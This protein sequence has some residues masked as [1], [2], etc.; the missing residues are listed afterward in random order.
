MKR[1]VLF[2]AFMVPVLLFAGG[3][4]EKK[5]ASGGEA[6]EKH[7]IVAANPDFESF[8][9]AIA[10]E[11]FSAWIMGSCYNTLME[12]D[13]SID[14]LIPRVAESYSVSGDGLSYTFSLRKDV[15]FSSGNPLSSADVK[16]S[17]ERVW[18]I[19]GNGSFMLGGVD[20]ID[21]PDDYTVIYRLKQVDPVFPTK[22]SYV[23]MDILDRKVAIEHGATNAEN[24]KTADTAKTW[25]DNNS[26]GSGPY[27]ILSYTPKVEVV[28]ERNP[29]YWRTPAYYDKITLKTVTDSN[30][31]LMMLRAGDVDIAYN[32]S[33]EQI[34][35]LQG[36]Q[37]ITIM[38]ARSLTTSFL[39]MN[40]DPGIG[41]PVANPKVQRAIRLALDY[42]G[43]QTIAGPRMLSP[44][45]PF[46]IGLAGSLQA[47]DVTG[48]P[49]VNEAKALLAEAGYPNGFSTKFYVP[50]NT[51]VGVDL[52]L[53]A[54]KVQNDLKAVGIN[55]ELV[56]ESVNISLATYRDGKQPLGLW[57]W[58]PDYIDNASQLAFLPGNTVGLRA[59][60]KEDQNPALAALGRSAAVE[61]DE[62]KR[63]ALIGQIQRAMIEDT[64]F[65]VLLQH[66]SQYAIRT[67]LTGA[68]YGMLRLDFK[69][70]AE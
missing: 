57:Y 29:N 65:A 56:P 62:A 48:Y 42:P 31:Q 44:Q 55:T 38:D 27:R 41:G 36:V 34:Q 32:L 33:P 12:Y 6:K 3:S 5:T 37:G 18:N 54:Q 49:R 24:A 43:I 35:T 11:P 70:I 21:T 52:V 66:S 23:T 46:P 16:W 67:G 30:A 7:L 26:A 69:R 60:W 22:L 20:K 53:L 19:R 25:L 45:A 28:L 64:P 39:L 40:R 51:V 14:K 63:M 61:T 8:D 68:D 10:Y 1:S 9:P 50:T 47:A 4:S 13:G 17:H 15:K 58:N 59:N 2:L